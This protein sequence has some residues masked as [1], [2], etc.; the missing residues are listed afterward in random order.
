M[1]L[2]RDGMTYFF[3]LIAAALIVRNAG[4]VDVV[5]TSV[6]R[7]ARAISAAILAPTPGGGGYTLA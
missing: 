3:G 7:G 4:Q 1:N 5:I 6:A 2:V